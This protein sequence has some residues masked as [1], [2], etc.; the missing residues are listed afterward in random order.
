MAGG[1]L[2]GES[3]T[4][5]VDQLDPKRYLPFTPK[6]ENGV[7]YVFALVAKRLRFDVESVQVGF[8]DCRA[9][10]GGKPVRIEFEYRSRNFGRHRHN[11]RRCELV[12]CWKHD[13]PAMPSSLAPLELRKLFGCAREVFMVAYQEE[14]WQRL[15][16]GREPGGLLE[17]PRVGRTRRPLAGL[18]SADGGR[19]GHDH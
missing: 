8:P 12:V 4:L 6:N 9:T 15:P 11:P 18:P 3:F 2:K 1:Y 17:C 19:G 16:D 5:A 13:W 10:W 7:A 14:A